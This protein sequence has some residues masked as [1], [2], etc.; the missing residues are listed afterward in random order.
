MLFPVPG[1]SQDFTAKSKKS[2]KKRNGTLYRNLFDLAVKIL[3]KN[4]VVSRNMKVNADALE[5]PN[6]FLDKRM[7]L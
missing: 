3:S 6:S 1:R 7:I 5:F 4:L 2:K